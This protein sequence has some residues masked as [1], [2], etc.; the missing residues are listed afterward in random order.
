MEAM[1]ALGE[2]KSLD[3]FVLQHPEELRYDPEVIQKYMKR[4]MMCS[5]L[6]SA[7]K[8]R[9]RLQEMGF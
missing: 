8:T 7:Y 6:T 9:S 3:Q 4:M 5:N 2:L 1:M